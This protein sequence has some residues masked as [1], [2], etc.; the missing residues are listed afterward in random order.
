VEAALAC[1]RWRSASDRRAGGGEPCLLRG[2]TDH[3]RLDG[4]RV[5]RL[6]ARRLKRGGERRLARA[7]ALR[8]LLARDGPRFDE[9][10]QLPRRHT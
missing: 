7:R 5:Q 9:R 8:D 3:G 1:R 2:V 6:D 4:Q 10:P